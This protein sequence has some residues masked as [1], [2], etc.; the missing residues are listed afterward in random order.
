MPVQLLGAPHYLV[1]C[2][3]ILFDVPNTSRSLH[4]EPLGMLQGHCL[5]PGKANAPCN[6]Q[7]PTTDPAA[8]QL[9]AMAA[10]DS[11]TLRTAAPTQAKP[12]S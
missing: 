2:C 1:G 9:S 6:A 8:Q 10:G 3:P 7:V 5:L 4:T 12:Q 11:G